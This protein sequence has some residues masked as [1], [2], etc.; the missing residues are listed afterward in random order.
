[1]ETFN[2]LK[3]RELYEQKKLIY[4]EN[5]DKK[6][7]WS[8]YRKN[9]VLCSKASDNVIVTEYIKDVKIYDNVHSLN[10][11]ADVIYEKDKVAEPS[12]RSV[13]VHKTTVSQ[14][15]KIFDTKSSIK[16]LF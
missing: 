11:Y 2:L 7:V 1:M 16:T 10:D 5:P 6:I 3:F 12:K 13:R 9:K 15:N 14:L 4:K 8:K